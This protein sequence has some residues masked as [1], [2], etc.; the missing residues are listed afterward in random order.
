MKQ[1]LCTLPNC[2]EEVSGVKFT[3]FA[4]GMLSEPISDEAAKRL[5]SIPGYKEYAASVHSTGQGNSPVPAGEGAGH[6]AATQ[7]GSTD[8][9]SQGGD[10]GQ[11]SLAAGDG[12][13]AEG[14]DGDGDSDGDS[15]GE[16]DEEKMTGQ[17]GGGPDGDAKSGRGRRQRRNK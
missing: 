3:A 4:G 15:E 14:G 6:S 12:P 8:G 10:G 16:G 9:Q 13:G 11:H 5:C 7:G 17:E 2:S 1:V